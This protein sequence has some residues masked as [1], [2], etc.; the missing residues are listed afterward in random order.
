MAA[1]ASRQRSTRQEIRDFLR[2]GREFRPGS[3]RGRAGAASRRRSSPRSVSAARKVGFGWRTA[4]ERINCLFTRRACRGRRRGPTSS[5]GCSPSP[6]TSRDESGFDRVPDVRHLVDREDPWSTPGWSRYGDASVRGA[7]AVFF[8]GGQGM[9]RGRRRRLCGTA[10]GR[11]HPAR[12]AMGPRRGEP[13]P[14]ASGPFEESSS[15]GP[16]HDSGVHRAPRLP[17]GALRRRGQRTDAPRGRGRHAD[18]RPLRPDRPRPL[19][20][21]GPRV[22]ILCARPGCLQ[23]GDGD[24]GPADEVLAAIDRL[25]R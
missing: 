16:S 15:S 24:G 19:R 5:T 10:P 2:K 14:G 17:R 23:S 6:S 9:A 25:L 12:R 18:A 8:E 7:A 1:V 11:R 3:R 13:G 21:V 20:P 22:A 4:T